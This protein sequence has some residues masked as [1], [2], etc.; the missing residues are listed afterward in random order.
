MMAVA[1]RLPLMIE[2]VKERRSTRITM[3]WAA[4][5]SAVITLMSAGPVAADYRQPCR[6]GAAPAWDD[7][8]PSNLRL[9]DSE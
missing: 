7:L 1:S 3:I 6:Q 2:A 5:L 4:W 8:P 9:L